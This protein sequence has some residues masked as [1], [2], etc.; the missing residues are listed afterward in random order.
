MP[1]S[2]LESASS[3]NGAKEERKVPAVTVNVHKR[4]RWQRVPFTS[5]KPPPLPK[6]SVDDC[7]PIPEA[8]A[9]FFSL[10]TFSWI[11]PLLGLGYARP[12]EASDLY[13]LQDERAA[14]VIAEKINAS[15]ERRS[16]EAKEY[17]ARLA[18]GEISPGWRAVWWTLRGGRKQR[19]E[20]WRNHTGKKRP[21]LAWA[22]NDS[23]KWW[24]WTAGVCKLISDTA[25]VTSPLL[26][27]AIINFGTQSYAGRNFHT[28]PV[29]TIGKGIGLVFGLLFLQMIAS[30]G[31]HHFFYRS[32]STGVLVRGG[33]I[34]AVYSRSLRLTSRARSTLTNGKLVNHIST[35][36]SRIDFCAG[37]FHMA[38]SS[39]VQM[40]ICL[41]LLLINLGPS[42]LAGFGFFVLM[43][44]VQTR[45]MKRMFAI[46]KKSM[47]WT[48]KRAKLLQELLGGM[49][50]IKF[51]AWENSFLDRVADYRKREMLELRTLLLIRSANNAVATGMPV[52]A[53]VISFIVYS[54]SG[55]DLDPAIIFSS[56]TLFNL[57]R[58]PL[59]FLRRWFF[60]DF[61]H[62]SIQF[63][64]YSRL[65]ERLSRCCTGYQPFE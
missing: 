30:I 28:N 40:L 53:S 1:G 54:V 64:F 50:V 56:L 61:S 16:K 15:Y 20:Q 44:P 29:P 58:L 19:E 45:V 57:L 9:S 27:K 49:K 36:I 12:L 39:P 35:D 22:L 33:L 13:K 60:Y 63:I 10:L 11:T 18:A 55:H 47:F 31:V 34:T 25:Q 43:T 48:D 38:W 37:F 14:A 6:P 7:E 65:S 2:D 62:K 8:T 41:I 52:L 42:A 24:F 5:T 59:M 46:R 3:I 4:S 21:S 32:T 51:F 23:V 26:V 17:N